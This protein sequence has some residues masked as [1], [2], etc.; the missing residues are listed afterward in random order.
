MPRDIEFIPKELAEQPISIPRNPFWDVCRRFGRDEIIAM[1]VNVIGTAII[2]IFVSVPII[3]SIAG[4]VIEKIGF[5]PANFWEARKIYRT[6]PKKQ[7]K[8][9]FHYFKGAMKRSLTSLTE[10]IL[11]HDPLYI[12][13]M[14]TGLLLFP[15]IPAWLLAAVSFT[16]AVVLVTVLEVGAR[17]L[18]Y[19]KFKL[20]LGK[21]G[22]EP[23]HYFETRFL[24]SAKETPAELMK[25]LM[26][27]FNLKQGRILQ[28]EDT[29]FENNL[30]EYSGRIPKVRLRKRTFDSKGRWIKGLRQVYEV[31]KGAVKTLQIIYTRASEQ[32]KG[33]REQYRYFPIRKEKFY[34]FI[35]QKMP[36]DI[37]QVEN[38]KAKKI[39]KF[40]E[41][42][43]LKKVH[44][45]RAFI[46]NK[47]L[48][49][50]VDKMIKGS[51][52]YILEIKVRKDI[53]L[54][55]EAMRYVMRE[56]PVV[57]TTKGKSEIL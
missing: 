35:N 32:Q 6:T 15:S 1:L 4:P 19:L 40:S 7:R 27:T 36:T 16:I 48:L 22:F 28:Y 45:E 20:R 34:S 17:E 2:S 50:S 42:K 52:F 25:K 37:S 18:Q 43:P 47:E 56:F 11:V 46:R 9:M 5:F 49:I 30:P 44:F 33:K 13:F 8:S 12:L 14:F 54:L 3:L 38:K 26:K 51:R 39:L 55:I 57:Q 53:K 29:Y 24:I 31:K 23:E 41:N 21:A 10:D